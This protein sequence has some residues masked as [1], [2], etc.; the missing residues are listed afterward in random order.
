MA[1]CERNTAAA[2]SQPS[3]RGRGR[4]GEGGSV[5]VI[6]GVVATKDVPVEIAAIGNVEAFETV[7]IRSQLTG[8]LN[9]VL[10]HEGDSVTRNQIIFQIDARPYQAAL[11][12]AKANLVRDQALLAQSEAQLNRDLA[13]ADYARLTAT[14]NAELTERGIVAK[15]TTEQSRAAADAMAATVNADRAA[16][17]SARAQLTAQQA[18]VENAE[19]Q[20][21]Y[22]TIRSPLTGRTGNLAIKT[23][24]L[25]TANTTELTTIAQIEPVYVTFAVPALHLTAIK[26]Q[27]AKEAPLVTASPQETGA[28]TA[29]G[30]LAFIDNAVDASTDTIKLKAVFDNKDRMLWPGQFARVNLRLTTL[31]GALI[32]ASQAVQTGQ[33]GQFVFVVKPDSTVEQRPVTVGQRV[34]QDIVITKGLSAGETIVT[35]GQLRLEPGSRIAPPGSGPANGGGGGRGGRGGG[36]GGRGRES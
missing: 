34:D 31:N 33:D 19:V 12:Q 21:G 18:A 27:M 6:T 17:A 30:H 9:E 5:P 32:V 10:F 22:T 24:G 28:A 23:G 4:G 16:V 11:D 7:S 3:G 20:L 8:M 36:R 15:D 25:V 35:E 26:N 2:G 1:G 14:R 29:A 13:Q